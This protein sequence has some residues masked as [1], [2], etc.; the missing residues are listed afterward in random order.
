MAMLAM[1][2]FKMGFVTRFLSHPVLSGFTSA[3]A[4]IIG[5][6]QVRAEIALSINA[7]FGLQYMLFIFSFFRFFL[8]LF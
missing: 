4:L 3:A 5:F 7:N 6:G 1:G 2:L 8:S